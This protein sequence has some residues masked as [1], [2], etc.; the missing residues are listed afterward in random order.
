MTSPGAKAERRRR[1]FARDEHRCV[2]CGRVFPGDRL[3]LDHVEPRRKGGDHS[4]GNLVTACLPCNRL[5][6]GR[7][8]WSF[9]ATDADARAAFLRHA[10]FVWPRHRRAVEEAAATATAAACEGGVSEGVP[11]RAP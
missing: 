5:K 2:Y 10:R 6:G 9:L 3:S 11:E 1:I 7:P 8:A 4:D